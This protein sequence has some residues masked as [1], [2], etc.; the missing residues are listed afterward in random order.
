MIVLLIEAGVRGRWWMSDPGIAKHLGNPAFGH[1][2]L[3]VT[4]VLMLLFQ[5]FVLVGLLTSGGY[6]GNVVRYILARQCASGS[7]DTL[8]TRLCLAAPSERRMD[9]A[10]MAIRETAERRMFPSGIVTCAVRPLAS[11]FT[12]KT[13]AQAVHVRCD[14]WLV[15]QVA[16]DPVIA[17]TIERTVTAA[18]TLMSD[19]QYRIDGWHEDP[20]S[21]G[22][23]LVADAAGYRD[24]APKDDPSMSAETY[25]R[26]V[27]RLQSR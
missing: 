25:R 18:L 3:V 27:E 8:F 5:S 11:Q 22:W 9:A 10:T 20:S 19:G 6:D 7:K 14:R 21:S 16:R 4:G 1:R 15:S 17:E 2:L 13:C 26:A 12:A 23:Q 24:T